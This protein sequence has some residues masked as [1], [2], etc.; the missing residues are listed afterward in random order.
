MEKIKQNLKI[1]KDFLNF[2]I[3]ILIASIYAGWHFTIWFYS[4]IGYGNEFAIVILTVSIIAAMYLL[5]GEFNRELNLL[6]KS[7][8]DKKQ[9]HLSAADLQRTACH[10]AGHAIVL[11]LACKCYTLNCISIRHSDKS[12]GRVSYS[13]NTRYLT[14]TDMLSDI[15]FSL[16]GMVAEKLIMGEHSSGCRSDIAEAK[17]SAS[18]MLMDYAM[19]NRFLYTTS[20]DQMYEIECERILVGAETIVERILRDKNNILIDLTEVLKVKGYMNKKEI[21]EFF[22]KYGI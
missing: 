8:H 6:I 16:A 11:R 9:K 20:Q 10:E 18:L 19:G 3:I 4:D 7:Y 22:N 15:E 12:S 5:I 21:E 14:K 17:K 13:Y 2:K 1:I